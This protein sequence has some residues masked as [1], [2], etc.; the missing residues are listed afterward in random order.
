L[1]ILEKIAGF[2][3]KSRSHLEK[4]KNWGDWKV[5]GGYSHWSAYGWI[6]LTA[7]SSFLIAIGFLVLTLGL[8]RKRQEKGHGLEPNKANCNINSRINTRYLSGFVVATILIT[9]AMIL[10]PCVTALSILIKE[11]SSDLQR[12]QGVLGILFFISAMGLGLFYAFR[13]G[14]LGWLRSYQKSNAERVDS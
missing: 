7:A 2:R 14:D 13:K 4:A 10:A 3:S 9:Q 12:S 11:G 6:F 1:V 8:H 5:L